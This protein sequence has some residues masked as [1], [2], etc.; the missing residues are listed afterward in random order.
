[1]DSIYRKIVKGEIKWENLPL[2]DTI[3][4]RLVCRFLDESIEIR[5]L[6]DQE[7]NKPPFTIT[8]RFPRNNDG[9]WSEKEFYSG[10]RSFDFAFLYKRPELNISLEGELQVRTIL[11]H[12]WADVSHDTFY[13]NDKIQLFP[14]YYSEGLISQMHNLSDILYSIDK[15]FVQLRK[16]AI[17]DH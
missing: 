13:K 2:E 10:Y 12:A 7:L 3:G 4:Y 8:S 11:Q 16:L 6:L 14:E 9:S 1:M 15:N 5:D 17:I